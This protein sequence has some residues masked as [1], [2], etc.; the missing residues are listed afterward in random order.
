MSAIQLNGKGRKWNPKSVLKSKSLEH[1]QARYA[2]LYPSLKAEEVKAIYE[3]AQASAVSASVTAMGKSSVSE[4]LAGASASQ[5]AS[6]SSG[7]ASASASEAE[8]SKSKS[9]KK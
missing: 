9:S 2:V 7:S 6:S 5:G 8:A 3:Q 1:L 4:Q